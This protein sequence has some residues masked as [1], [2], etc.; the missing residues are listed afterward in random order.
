MTKDEILDSIKIKY[1]NC[2][3]ELRE[4]ELT[5]DKSKRLQWRELK[6]FEKY[7]KEQLGL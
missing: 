6:R 1:K 4:I 3:K 5:N 2:L 7:A